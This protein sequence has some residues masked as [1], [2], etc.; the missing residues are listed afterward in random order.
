MRNLTMA[1]KSTGVTLCTVNSL[2]RCVVSVAMT[3]LLKYLLDLVFLCSDGILSCRLPGPSVALRLHSSR[4]HGGTASH[5]LVIFTNHKK[6]CYK[7]HI[8]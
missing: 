5:A 1:A 7:A 6:R 8:T 4:G 3:V 2:I